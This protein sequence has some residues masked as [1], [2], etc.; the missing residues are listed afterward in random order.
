MASALD[1]CFPHGTRQSYGQ[2]KKAK[3]SSRGAKAKPVKAK[4]KTAK[5]AGGKKA[6][7][8]KV[9]PRRATKTAKKPAAQKKT[10]APR[11]SV[12]TKGKKVTLGRPQVTGEEKLYLLFKE[13]FHARQIFAFLGVETVRELEEHSPQEIVKQ[14]SL[15]IRQAVQRIRKL[16]AEK[17]RCLRDDTEFALLQKAT[18]P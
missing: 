7:K 16:L 13:D 6:T 8:K 17:N 9:T 4:K 18:H 15:P 1:R 12:S 14:L 3:R 11:R 2:K 5:S 10:T